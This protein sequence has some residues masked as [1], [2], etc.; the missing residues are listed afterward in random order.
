MM[1]SIFCSLAN[2]FWIYVHFVF[3]YFVQAEERAS[4]AQR[5]KSELDS[6]IEDKEEDYN[7]LLRKHKALANQVSCGQVSLWFS[8]CPGFTKDNDKRWVLWGSG[9]QKTACRTIPACQPFVFCLWSAVK[10]I[11][12]YRAILWCFIGHR[13]LFLSCL[14]VA[15]H[16][17]L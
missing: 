17:S 1:C 15:L 4:R 7:E 12:T 14:N 2:I 9:F 16:R 5:E 8:K 11:E 3:C 6:Q 10:Y 13:H